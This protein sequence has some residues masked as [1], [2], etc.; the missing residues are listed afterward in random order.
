MSQIKKIKLEGVIPATLIAFDEDFEINENASRKHIKECALTKGI[1]AITVNGHSSEI[2]ACN[3]EEQKTILNFSLDEIGDVLPVINGVYADGSI[4]AAKIAKMSDLN[5]ASALLCFPPQSM[6]MGGYLRP[7]MAV[8]HFSRIADA[9]DLPLICFNYPSSGNLTYPFETLLQ[10]FEKIPSIKAIKDWSNDPMLHEKHIKTFQNLSNPVNVLT[11]HSSW[12]MSSLVMGA[13]GLLSG[14]GS[15][16]ASLQVD[17]F[18]AIKNNDLKTAQK[19]NDK[20]YP[21]VQAFYSP[22]FLDMHN[23]MKETLVLLGLMEKAIVRPPL[24]KLG[25]KEITAL[26]KAI[27]QSGI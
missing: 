17:L 19:I 25:F 20:M 9:S 24:M 18:L 23:R 12:L 2:H 3:F 14:A 8:E 7:E 11:T 22:P 26:E 16:I 13:K 27:K 5:G 10:M 4:E 21:L 6:S 15:V 1:S